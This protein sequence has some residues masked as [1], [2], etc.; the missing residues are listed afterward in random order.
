MPHLLLVIAAT[1]LS[2]VA[3]SDAER[4]RVLAGEVLVATAADG[5]DGAGP[6]AVRAAIRIDA[7]PE[8]VFAVM[9]SCAEALRFVRRLESCRVVGAAQDG[10]YELIEQVVNLRWYLPR[11]RFVFR[12]D[13]ERPHEVRI[14]NVSGGLREH[15][16]RWTLE[17]LD[18]G[19]A[20]LVG[21]RVRVVPRYPVPEWL[22]LAAL[23]RDLPDTLR[24]LAARCLARP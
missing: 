17:P 19:A 15:T 23:K 10:S 24:E 2:A 21:Y 11:I 1:L 4:T 20:T 6:P 22:V 12:A 9:T 14:R 16:A 8:R 13:Y 5:A 3:L 7:A 18:G